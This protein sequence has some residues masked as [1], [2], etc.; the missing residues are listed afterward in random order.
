MPTNA[1]YPVVCI[2]T[3]LNEDTK[4]THTV[5]GLIGPNS[6]EVNYCNEV[7]VITL[8]EKGFKVIFELQQDNKNS[9]VDLK[10]RYNDSWKAV[11]VGDAWIYSNPEDKSIKLQFFSLVGDQ[12]SQIK[13]W[14]NDPSCPKF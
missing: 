3:S 12:L 4:E 13:E 8:S 1:V 9:F 5:L 14:R 2:E 7:S 11:L 10:G 6:T